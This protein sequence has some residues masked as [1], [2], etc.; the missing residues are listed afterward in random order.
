[1]PQT[2]GTKF[3]FGIIVS[4][5]ASK[6]KSLSALGKFML[7]ETLTGLTRDLIGGSFATAVQGY[8]EAGHKHSIMSN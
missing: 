2:E 5:A 6:H 3:R 8:P 1:L 7:P 4:E